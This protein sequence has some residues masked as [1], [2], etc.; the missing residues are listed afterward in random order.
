MSFRKDTRVLEW[1]R[2][3]PIEFSLI[4][5][6]TFTKIQ[7][8]RKIR[9]ESSWDGHVWLW[10]AAPFK[11]K[12]PDNSWII[13]KSDP[14]LSC[15]PEKDFFPIASS[16]S[17]MFSTSDGLIIGISV[18]CWNLANHKAR[19]IMLIY[20]RLFLSFEWWSS[21]IIFGCPA[22]KNCQ[23]FI[24]AKCR[25]IKIIWAVVWIGAKS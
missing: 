19:I 4:W 25:L 18:R 11:H 12:N 24:H 17:Q 9:D 13:R 23:T 10:L 7:I 14:E 1:F 22:A 2:R 15:E 3:T 20:L 6:E 8:H 21:R 5:W 16:W